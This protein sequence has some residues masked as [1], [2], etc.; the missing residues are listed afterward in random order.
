MNTLDMESAGG[1]E[2]LKRDQSVLE[3][4]KNHTINA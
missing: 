1:I 3:K 2:S 4:K